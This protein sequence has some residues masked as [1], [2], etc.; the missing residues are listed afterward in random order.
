MSTAFDQETRL[1]PLELSF[2]H[3]FQYCLGFLDRVSFNE[4]VVNKAVGN[5]FGALTALLAVQPQ[6]RIQAR[7]RRLFLDSTQLPDSY[8]LQRIFLRHQCPPV[9]F[10][11]GIQPAEL[12]QCLH[13]MESLL[14][15]EVD[16]VVMG[17]PSKINLHYRW[18]PASAVAIPT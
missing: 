1:S 9:C 8:V 14:R 5:L 10:Q 7:E 13:Q 6:V 3:N 16:P 12:L 17:V 4:A 2:L 15:R 11:K 18:L